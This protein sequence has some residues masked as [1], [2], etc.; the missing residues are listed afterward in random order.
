V[1]ATATVVCPRLLPPGLRKRPAR[2]PF[3]PRGGSNRRK[4]S[5]G[6]PPAS[7]RARAGHL[8]GVRNGGASFPGDVAWLGLAGVTDQPIV[9]DIKRLLVRGSSRGPGRPARLRGD[10]KLA[11]IGAAEARKGAT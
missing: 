1:A 6:R 10:R 2:N 4:R 8:G 5:Y 7:R 11:M 3:A 9:R